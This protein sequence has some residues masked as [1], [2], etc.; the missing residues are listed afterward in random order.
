MSKDKKR[1][2]VD[3]KTKEGLVY[4]EIWGILF[5]LLALILL[6]ELGPVGGTLNTLVKMIFGDWYWLVLIFMFYYGVMMIIYHEFITY[7]SIKIKGFIFISA[8]LLIYSHFPIYNALEDYLD[9]SNIVSESYKLFLSYLD[10]QNEN[11]TYGGGLLGAFL[12]WICYVLLGEIGTKIIAI[13]LLISG[14]AYLFEKTIYDFIDEVYFGTIKVYKKTKKVILSTLDKM[15]EVSNYNKA[16]QK[17]VIIDSV[18]VSNSEN[19][20]F[21]NIVFTANERIEARKNKY[22]KPNLKSLKY[23]DNKEILEKQ[24][25]ITIQN[26]KTINEFLK[27][28]FLNLEISEVYIGPTISTYIIEVENSLKSK[29]IMNY[30]KDLNRRLEVDFIRM[31]EKYDNKQCVY[32]EVPN[33]YRYLVSLREILEEDEEENTIPIGRNYCGRL[34]SINFSKMSNILV[35]GNDINSKIDLLKT[36]V[37]VIYY[38]FSPDKF[39]LVLCD[40]TKFELNTFEN[41]DHLFYPFISDFQSMRSMLIKLYTEVEKRLTNLNDYGQNFVP[42]LLVLNDFVDFYLNNQDYLKYLNYIL[43]YGGK[44]SVYTIYATNNMDEKILT[45][46]LCAQFNA[47][48]AFMI[49]NKEIS[50]KYLEDDTTKLLKKGD[51]IVYTRWDNQN[52]RVQTVN[53]T[54]EDEFIY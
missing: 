40:S 8:G 20:R 44:V 36:I 35:I 11:G 19:R 15:K 33:K 29:K 27:S 41:I 14:V 24:K 31:Y 21:D 10:N 30:Q 28:F 42:I 22:V 43:V 32:I 45:N 26:A 13:F 25:E 46:N 54:E 47:I 53:L 51:C 5:I 34:Y 4:F 49:N 50:F 3:D 6:S 48:I 37:N 38:K 2:V 7:S 23:H 9:N 39:R 12:F 18:P 1:K 17:E 52:I 16:Q